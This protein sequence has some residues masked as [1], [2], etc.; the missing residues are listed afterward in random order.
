MERPNLIRWQKRFEFYKAA[1]ARLTEAID[2]IKERKLQLEED[3]YLEDALQESL[4]QRYEYTFELSWK[5]MKDF[6]SQEGGF[7]LM[8]ARDSIREA[9]KAELLDDGEIWMDM[10]SARNTSS[11]VYNESKIIKIF[12]DIQQVYYPQFITFQQEIEARL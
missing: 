9:F 8:G 3:E 5:V 1:L 6:L 2:Q 7:K 11:H 4:I 10:L 12:R